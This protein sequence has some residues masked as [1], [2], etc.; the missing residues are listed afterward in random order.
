[1][2]LVDCGVGGE[3]F[4]DFRGAGQHDAVKSVVA[5]ALGA[6]Q[7]LDCVRSA[8]LYRNIIL[9]EFILTCSSYTT[10]RCVPYTSCRRKDYHF[11]F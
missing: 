6:L 3:G 4:Q 9:N 8:T 2:Q 1:M 10:R 11:D 7:V 5:P